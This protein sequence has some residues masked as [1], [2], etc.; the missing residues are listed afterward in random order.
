LHR[1][2][3]NIALLAAAAAGLVACS[4]NGARYYRPI[5][6]YPQADASLGEKLAPGEADSAARVAA[7]IEAHLRHMYAA[8]TIYRDAHPKADGCVKAT[9]TVEAGLPALLRRGLFHTAKS[10]DAVIRFSNSSEDR[11]RADTEGDGRGMAIKVLG[12]P[13]VPLTQDPMGPASQ[14]F[15]LINHPTFPVADPTKYATLI[16][17]VDSSD[18]LTNFFTP[19]LSF[20]LLGW[21]GAKNATETTAS[22]IDSPLNTRYWSMVPYQLGPRGAAV[23]VKYSAAP[24]VAHAI[25]LPKTSDPNYLRHVMA[26]ALAPGSSSACMKLMVQPR[27]SDD[28]SVEDS[29]MEW[30][31][32]AA[33]FYKVATISIPAQTFDTPQQNIACEKLSYS[34]WHARAEH[35]PL[36]AMN[37]MRKAI[38]ER[39]S[40]VRR[41]SPSPPD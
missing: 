26:A 37:R 35:K 16:G 39:I 32:A 33:P 15:I 13:E 1:R 3:L 38:Y 24:C 10:Y 17:Y 28:M 31:E 23:A 12:I 36:G 2:M 34:P 20:L 14:D 18:K 27:T 25:V 11:T 21:T 6:N 22:H 9:L 5:D 41:N 29:R 40:A 7:I 8:G 19:I 30:H 4:E